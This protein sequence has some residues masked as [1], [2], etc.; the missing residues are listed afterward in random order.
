MKEKELLT[1]KTFWTKN[2]KRYFREKE[3]SQFTRTSK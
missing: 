1:L 3:E 2:S